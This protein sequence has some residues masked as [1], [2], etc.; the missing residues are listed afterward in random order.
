[1][2]NSQ[3]FKIFTWALGVAVV[4]AGL[5]AW[6]ATR[7]VDG[8]IGRYEL[9]PILG[10]T[11]FSLM[12]THYVSDALRRKLGYDDS[13]I[14]QYFK[15]T[16]WIVLV[17]ILAHPLLFYVQLYRDGL[18]VPPESYLMVYT[19]AV[20]RFALIL[21][22]LSLFA[23][24]AFEL[25]RKFKDASWW[26]FVEYANVV[27]MFAIFYHALRL[28]GE[29]ASGWFRVLWFFYAITLAIAIAYTYA[30]KSKVAVKS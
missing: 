23:F 15:I 27:A 3:R 1:M 5:A 10:I 17:C 20:S 25:H 12:W 24:L 14:R 28:G 19:D 6:S 7:L 2:M 8:E 18:G 9:F 26:R 4:V 21:G 11:A 30:H 13:V 29:V 16:A 22:T